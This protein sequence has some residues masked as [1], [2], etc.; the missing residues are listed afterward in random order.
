LQAARRSSVFP[1][2]RAYNDAKAKGADETTEASAREA[3][4]N[5][6]NSD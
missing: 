2:G 3:I 6:L 1:G 4:F 5:S